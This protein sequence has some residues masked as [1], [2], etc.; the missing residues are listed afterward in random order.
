MFYKKELK[1]SDQ[2]QFRV[3]K[4][5]KWKDDELYVNWKGY[6]NSWNSWIDEELWNMLYKLM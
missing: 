5:I 2:K 4:A 3:E 1:K 6:S